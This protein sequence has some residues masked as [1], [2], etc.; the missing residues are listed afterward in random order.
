MNFSKFTSLCSPSLPASLPF[1]SPLPHLLSRI[2]LFPSAFLFSGGEKKD[3]NS[4]WFEG[5]LVTIDMFK[6]LVIN[7]I[8]GSNE[9]PQRLKHLRRGQIQMFLPP[10]V[11]V[12]Y[13]LILCHVLRKIFC[14]KILNKIHCIYQIP[15]GAFLVFH[16][17]II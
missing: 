6:D 17:K 16:S 14:S 15:A 13:H 10:Q 9:R 12:L 8:Y 3:V 7:A 5:N 4:E 2:A 11:T 1:L